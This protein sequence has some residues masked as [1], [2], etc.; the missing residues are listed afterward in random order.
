MIQFL[1]Q[2]VK[3]CL[4]AL[5]GS[6]K[7]DK[8]L[9]LSRSRT[10]SNLLRSL[11]S[12]HPDVICLGEIFGSVGN[13]VKND[14]I[15]SPIKYLKR[16]AFGYHKKNI[17]SVGFKIFYYHPEFK[18]STNIWNYLENQNNIKIIHLKRKN[19]LRTIL[20]RK[21]AGKTQS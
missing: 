13:E 2:I 15:K 18:C 20:S 4:V 17:K 14:I 3:F 6:K 16:I 19:I 21:I 10:G 11:L 1:K 8:F 12:S 9:I 7:Y 5:R